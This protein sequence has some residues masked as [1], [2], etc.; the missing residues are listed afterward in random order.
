MI[1]PIVQALEHKRKTLGLSKSELIRRAEGD[2]VLVSG[3][4]WW[5][6]ADGRV[7]RPTIRTL[8]RYARALG[9][10][11]DVVPQHYPTPDRVPRLAPEA[12]RAHGPDPIDVDI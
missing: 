2:D 7:D 6:I 1:D 11:I 10:D 3:A 12:L 8:R 4:A 5:R 9:Y